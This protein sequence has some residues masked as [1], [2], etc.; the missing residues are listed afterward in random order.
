MVRAREIHGLELSVPQEEA[1]LAGRVVVPADDFSSR[2][3]SQGYGLRCLRKQN[4]VIDPVGQ[5][6][7]PARTTFREKVETDDVSIG[8][9]SESTGRGCAR[10]VD[11]SKH[12]LIQQKAV[13]AG[14][15]IGSDDRARG[16]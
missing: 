4:V 2:V 3:D 16:T 6:E 11:A 8:V 9:D 15:H 12:A 14:Q 10:N 1:V 7:A 13:R 5:Q